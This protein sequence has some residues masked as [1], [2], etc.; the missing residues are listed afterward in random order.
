MHLAIAAAADLL[1]LSYLITVNTLLKGF[2]QFL[3]TFSILTICCPLQ[4]INNPRELRAQFTSTIAAA[5]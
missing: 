5:I 2:I 4:L 3:R 1:S